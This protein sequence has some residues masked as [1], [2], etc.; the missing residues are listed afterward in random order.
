[1]ITMRFCR[2][3]AAPEHRREALLA[4]SGL[5]DV[6]LDRPRAECMAEVVVERIIPD[7]LAR[8]QRA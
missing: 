6:R 1:M 5:V 2:L 8:T 3:T 7:S 4:Q